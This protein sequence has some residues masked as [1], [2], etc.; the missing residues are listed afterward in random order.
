[1][2]DRGA[3]TLLEIRGVGKRFGGL[4]ALTD[5]DLTIWPGEILGVI[6]PIGAG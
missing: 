6:C 5:V 3:A 1:M 4:A 2:P